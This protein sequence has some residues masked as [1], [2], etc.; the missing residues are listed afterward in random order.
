MLTGNLLILRMIC[1]FI[2]VPE[3][4]HIVPD[5]MGAPSGPARKCLTLVG[6]ILSNLANNSFS[7]SVNS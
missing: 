1:P 5:D 4:Y 6:K 3:F 7:V 2:S